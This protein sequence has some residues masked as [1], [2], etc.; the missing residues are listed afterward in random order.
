MLN[1]FILIGRLVKDEKVHTFDDGNKVLEFTLAVRR[2]Y[3]NQQGEYET[4]FIRIKAYNTLADRFVS[5]V[6]KGDLITIIGRVQ[7]KKIDLENEKY[8]LQNDLITDRIIFVSTPDQKSKDTP[9]NDF[10]QTS[11]E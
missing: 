10:E 5:Y 9:L 8:Y 6:R 4:D 7:V 1:Q 11:E 3:K 2:P